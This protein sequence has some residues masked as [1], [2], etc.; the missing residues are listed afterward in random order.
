MAL[1]FIA[2]ATIGFLTF[3]VWVLYKERGLVNRLIW[4]VLIMTLGNIAM[5]GYVL[6]Q[7]FRLPGGA[8]VET[9]LLRAAAK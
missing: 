2:P 3:Y 4:F 5:S 7:L 6:V 1:L 8:S 9:L